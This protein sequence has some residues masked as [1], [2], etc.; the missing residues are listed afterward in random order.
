MEASDDVL[1]AVHGTG[2]LPLSYGAD[3]NAMFHRATTFVH[4]IL[5]GEKPA[6]LPITGVWR[7]LRLLPHWLVSFPGLIWRYLRAPAHDA[8]IVGYMG[9]LDVLVL[10]PLAR[11]RRDPM[12]ASNSRLI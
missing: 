6:D 10:W 1:E 9:H 8:V 12:S 7:K 4:K 11:S 3:R 5:K 2:G